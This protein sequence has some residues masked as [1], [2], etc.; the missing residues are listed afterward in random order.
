[1]DFPIIDMEIQR[2]LR[3]EDTIGFL[4]ARL[5]KSQVVIEDIQVFA[6]TQADGLV[7]VAAEAGAVAGFGSFGLDLVPALALASVERRV[8]VDQVDAF[9]LH[10]LQD[11]QV[12]AKKYC[13]FH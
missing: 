12:I 2:P 8:D 4:Q 5:Q 1:M 13:V 3:R 7:A 6:A 11:R 9:G 10:L